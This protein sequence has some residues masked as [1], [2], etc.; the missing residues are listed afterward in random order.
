M[1]CKRRGQ[2]LLQEILATREI[3]ERAL[4]HRWIAVQ[5]GKSLQEDRG[6]GKADE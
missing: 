4:V 2:L 3:S 1:Q 5:G 6:G